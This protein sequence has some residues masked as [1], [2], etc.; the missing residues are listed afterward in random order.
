M[1]NKKKS[2]G[3]SWTKEDIK[4]PPHF[5]PEI[6]HSALYIWNAGDDHKEGGNRIDYLHKN[7]GAKKMAFIMSILVLPDLIELIMNKGITLQDVFNTN[8]NQTKH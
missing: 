1:P 3:K 4:F 8:M 5:T 6:I 2:F 7:L